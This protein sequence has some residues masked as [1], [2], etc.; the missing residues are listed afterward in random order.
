[1]KRSIR[2]ISVGATDTQQ[3]S[4]FKLLWSKTKLQ[5]VVKDN[6]LEGKHRISKLGQSKGRGCSLLYVCWWSTDGYWKITCW[7]SHS[8]FSPFDFFPN[9]LKWSVFG[10][11][12]SQ[13]FQKYFLVFPFT[14]SLSKISLLKISCWLQ[15]SHIPRKYLTKW[16]PPG[17]QSVRTIIVGV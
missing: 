5:H 1:M 3:G 11:F 13:T 9:F 2:E 12:A 16:T 8:H 17:K 10:G 15:S 14:F 7:F 4:L 6:R